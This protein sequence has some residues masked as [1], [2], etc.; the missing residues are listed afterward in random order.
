MADAV[1]DGLAHGLVHA[2]GIRT[3]GGFPTPPE[4]Y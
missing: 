4:G 1:S 2:V 3:M